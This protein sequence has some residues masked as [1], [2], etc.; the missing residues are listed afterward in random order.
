MAENNLKRELLE[1]LKMGFESNIQRHKVNIQVLLNNAVGVAE[2]PDVMETVEG[3]L[4]KMA[5]YEDKLEM[6]QKYF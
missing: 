4:S 2:H 6:L 5:E 3:E 1:A